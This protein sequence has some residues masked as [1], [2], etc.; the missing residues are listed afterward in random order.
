MSKP[1]PDISEN[2]ARIVREA[3]TKHEGPLPAD[4]ERAWEVWSRGIAKVDQRTE[5]FC[6]L[7]LKQDLT[8]G[9]TNRQDA[10]SMV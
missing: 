1:K 2:A 7:R 4:L 8:P 6:G 3:T 9:R 5:R 10:G